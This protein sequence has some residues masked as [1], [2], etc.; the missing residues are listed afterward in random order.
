MW[1]S[2][3]TL[4]NRINPSLI[5]D[6]WVQFYYRVTSGDQELLPPAKLELL[7][8]VAAAEDLVRYILV[9]EATHRPS[10]DDVAFRL[11]LVLGSGDG[12]PQRGDADI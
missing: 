10:I 2:I 4:S 7:G 5:L 3:G 9:R 8:G 12:G 11:G 1:A 6:D